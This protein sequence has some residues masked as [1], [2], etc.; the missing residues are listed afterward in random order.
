VTARRLL[1]GVLVDAV[2]LADAGWDCATVSAATWRTLARVHTRRDTATALR[3][4]GIVRAGQV[5]AGAVRHMSA[6]GQP[7]A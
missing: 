4:D 1:P 6:G 2:A 3:G 7:T 5:L